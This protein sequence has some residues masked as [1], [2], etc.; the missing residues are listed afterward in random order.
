MKMKISYCSFSV[1]PCHKLDKIGVIGEGEGEEIDWFN[2]TRSSYKLNSVFHIVISITLT[3]L[4]SFG[5]YY[6]PGS[7]R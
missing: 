2:D 1:V 4:S 7:Y 6:D 3:G 5:V